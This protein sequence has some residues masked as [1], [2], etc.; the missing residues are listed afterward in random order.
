MKIK[1]FFSVI[2]STVL[3]LSMACG[4]IACSNDK[5]VEEVKCEH[6]MTKV[7]HKDATCVEEGN[8][9]HYVCSLCGKTYFD[10]GGSIELSAQNI[11]ISKVKHSLRYHQPEDKVP[12]YWYC[13]ACGKYF[14]DELAENETRYETLYADYYNPVKLADVTGNGDIFSSS[15]YDDFTFRCFISWQNADGK[16]FDDFPSSDKVQ[17]NINFNRDGAGSR[18]DWYNFG[19]GYGK[20]AGLFYKPVESGSIITASS[21]LTQLFLKQGGIYVVAVREGGTISAYFEDADGNL[22]LFTSGNKFGA[23]E[24]LV[25]LAANTAAGVD[26]WTVSVTETAICTGVADT[27]CIFDKAYET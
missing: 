8:I 26:G 7:A 23:D 18:V 6:I 16:S 24:A 5:P 4:F 12:E 20:N 17:V 9:A 13:F 19:I 22:K 15:L 1:K 11:A 3:A 2:S 14:T 27:K 21:K 25:R 10:E